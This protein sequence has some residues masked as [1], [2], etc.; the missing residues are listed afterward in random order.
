[1][2]KWEFHAKVGIHIKW[3]HGL[4]LMPETTVPLDI[5]G[6]V[7]QDMHGYILN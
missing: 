6:N 2:L 1:M 3:L 4:P 7:K 5:N